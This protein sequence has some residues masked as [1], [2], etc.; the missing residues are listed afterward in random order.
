MKALAIATERA[1]SKARLQSL[2]DADFRVRSLTAASCASFVSVIATR[3]PRK[4]GAPIGLLDEQRSCKSL[5]MINACNFVFCKRIDK[6]MRFAIVTPVLNGEKFLDQSILSVVSQTGPFTIRYHVQDGGSKDRTLE[7]LAA[8]KSRLARDFP[9]F[10]EGIEFSFASAPDRGV[11]DAL[12]RGF[13]ACAYAHADAMAW[14]NADDRFEPGAFATVEEI[15]R[16]FPDIDWVTGRTTV[17]SETGP[18][19]CMPPPIYAFPRKAIAAGIF[20]SRFAPPCIEQEATFWRPRLWQKAGGVDPNFRLAGDF[21]LWRRFARQTDLVS[22]DAILGCFRVRAGQLSADMARY[23]A[24]IDASL[25]PAE[26]ETRAKAAKSYA[27]AG[28]DYRVLV[29]YYGEPW[30]CGRWPMCIAPIFGT[31]AFKAENWRLRVMARF[32]KKS[33]G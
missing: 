13:A 26:I 31:K 33:S 29:R 21:D 17:I 10:C 23:R 24:E 27:R 9:V 25:S 1:D 32:A 7:I 30:L 11:Y 8:W 28:F 3:R 12:N 4:K 6:S 5:P 15:F 16:G 22:V 14:I 20:D 19:L 2:L 18:M